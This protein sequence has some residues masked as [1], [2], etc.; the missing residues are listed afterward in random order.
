MAKIKYWKLEV[1]GALW[2]EQYHY[3]CPGCKYV[4][5]IGKAVHSFN[6]DFDKPTFTP[7]VLL[8]NPQEVHRCHAIITDGNIQFQDDCW[9]DLKSQTV[10]LPE[11]EDWPEA[12]KDNYQ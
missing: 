10:P 9:H 1:D 11:Y 6:G 8:S 3:F 5:A 4:H 7:S 2:H 12:Y